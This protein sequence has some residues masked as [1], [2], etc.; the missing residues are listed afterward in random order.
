MT[1]TALSTPDIDT[2]YIVWLERQIDIIRERQF[3]QLDVENLLDELE[4]AVNKRKRALR[5]R[6]RVLMLHLLKCDYQP[7]QR[8]NSWISTICTQ[9]RKI[10][11]ALEDSPSLAHM[12]R[13]YAESEYKHAVLQ[14]AMETGLPESTFPAS[15]PYAEQQLLDFDFIPGL[16]K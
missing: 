12:V 8:S 7:L 14:A 3:A 15:P 4:Y 1:H 10:Y 9:R 13:A 5:S 11:E 16:V 2:D 6:L